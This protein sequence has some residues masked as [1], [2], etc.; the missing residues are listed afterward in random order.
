MLYPLIGT[1]GTGKTTFIVEK[2]KELVA[3]G[4]KVLL[5]VPEQF[6]F[7]ME[8]KVL[9]EVG[10]KSVG[11]VEVKSFSHFCRKVYMEFGGG[12]GEKISDAAKVMLMHI[13][14][15]AVRDK[16]EY[17]GRASAKSG[18]AASALQIIEQ[19]KNGGIMPSDLRKFSEFSDD[20]R[21]REKTAEI[22]EIYSVYQAYLEGDFVDEREDL[23][24]CVEIL[25][26]KNYFKDTNIILDSYRDFMPI[27]REMIS[28]MMDSCKDIYFSI[29]APDLSLKNEKDNGILNIVKENALKII[30][31]AKNKNISVA[32]P[33]YFTEAYRFKTED[34]KWLSEQLTKFKFSKYEGED[35]SISVYRAADPYEELHYVAAQI[36]SLVREEGYHYK[37][38]TII[39]RSL[40]NYQTMIEP[41][42][43]RYQIPL[44][45]DNRVD[46]RHI[47]LIRAILEALECIK[48]NFETNHVLA[49]AK[50]PIMGL[51]YT[52]VLELENY[53]Y[54]WN[55]R[56]DLWFADW[57]NNPRG[58]SSSFS[59]K[60]KEQLQN[61]KNTAQFIINPLLRLKENLKNADGLK[62]ASAIYAFLQEIQAK[63]NLQNAFSTEN[64]LYEE[65]LQQNNEAWNVLMDLLDVM[66]NLLKGHILPT[67]QLIELFEMGIQVCDYGEIPNTLDQV[68]I[69]TADRIRPNQP[70]VV[71]VIGFNRGEFPPKVAEQP[72]FSDSEREIL[73]EAGIQIGPTVLR[74]SSYEQMY[75][76]SALTAPSEKL[77]LTYHLSLGNGSETSPA[78]L[79][80][81][82]ISNLGDEIVSTRED[83]G[84]LFF[85]ANELTVFDTLCRYFRNDNSIISALYQQVKQTEQGQKI[86]KIE[87]LL[88]KEDF[89]IQ[90]QDLARQLF[91]TYMRLSPTNVNKYFSCPFSYFCYTGLHLRAR[92]KADYSSIEAG[93]LLH[94]LLAQMIIR[95]GGKGLKDLSLQDLERESGEIVD[96]YLEDCIG[97]PSKLQKRSQYLFK[98]IAH[99]ASFI[100]KQL[101]DEFSQSQFE[102]LFCELEISKGSVVPPVVFKTEDGIKLSIEGIVD[103]VDVM[104]KNGRNYA[105][106][107]DYKSREH[108]FSF[109]EMYYGLKLQ[110]LLYLLSICENG[111]GKLKNAVPA[112]VLYFPAHN[113]SFKVQRDADNSEIKLQ[114]RKHYKMTGLVLEDEDCIFGMEEPILKKAKKADDEQKMVLGEYI[115]VKSTANGW[116]ATQSKLANEQQMKLIFK[117]IRQLMTDMAQNLSQGKI[118]AFPKGTKSEQPCT[119]CEFKNI[120]QHQEN[121]KKFIFSSM[122]KDKCFDE[123]EKLYNDEEVF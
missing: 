92:K 87:K 7:E 47:S 66:A 51:D 118:E 1:S 16:L 15:S 99:K 21:L 11:L 13:A 28:V 48:S 42:F 14:L 101:G 85:A 17:Y 82:L 115:P 57:K 60:E 117:H 90:N 105:R 111:S 24:R 109:T 116:H 121:D 68:S 114:R 84:D 8:R 76:Y 23:A 98:S 53:C 113:A 100:L 64:L 62:F 120:C 36:A 18:F 79:L 27:E 46:I 78:P 96:K 107:I 122:K 26:G 6:S 12:A 77:F 119:F 52:A 35:R 67:E 59:E 29:L 69:G 74:Q 93:N 25:R 94:H 97:D 37:D 33:Q 91:G 19:F 39:A 102:P 65:I 54:T 45:W 110:M 50:S 49:L 55:I 44:F 88:N 104:D 9:L 103:R 73:L 56:K 10:T 83:L 31:L 123:L 112:G 43:K 61:I 2:I 75:I 20:E 72:F 3:L 89:I 108:K 38:F 80:L 41:L 22:F 32:S 81:D 30:S 40:E 70:K 71:F 4:E 106:V 86:S 5:L 58:I 63:D 95:Y 34:L